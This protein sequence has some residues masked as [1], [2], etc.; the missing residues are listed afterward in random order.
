MTSSSRDKNQ[1]KIFLRNYWEYYRELEDE[2]LSTKRYVAFSKDNFNTYS[3]EYLKLYQAVCSEIDVIGKA[4]AERLNP[5]FQADDKKIIYINGGMRCR[6]NSKSLKKANLEL[7]IALKE[8][9]KQ[10]KILKIIFWIF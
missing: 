4:L 8:L 10:F 2:F 7:S 1:F 9:E 6:I 3:V 5:K